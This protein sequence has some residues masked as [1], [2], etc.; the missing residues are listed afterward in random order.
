MF[1]HGEADITMI[2]IIESVNV[3]KAVMRMLRDDLDM[4]GLLVCYVCWD[5]PEYKMKREPWK[6]AVT[7]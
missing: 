2:Y 3:G 7:Q 1:S 5:E 6:W 4:Y